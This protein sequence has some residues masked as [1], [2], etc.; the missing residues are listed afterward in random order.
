[1]FV[2]SRHDLWGT[3][4]IH[5]G[6][7]V[8]LSDEKILG[9][10]HPLVAEDV[11]NLAEIMTALV[12]EDKDGELQCLCSCTRMPLTIDLHSCNAGTERYVS[13]KF[14]RPGRV[15]CFVVLAM[16]WTSHEKTMA[17][18]PHALHS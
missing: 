16:E 9:C 7:R 8:F 12:S 2:A 4:L 17:R 10:Y 14:P 18:D 5:V 1:M 13:R 11:V 15:V 3:R 6:R